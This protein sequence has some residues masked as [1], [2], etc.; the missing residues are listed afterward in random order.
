MIIVN[1][2]IDFFPL[3]QMAR[4]FTESVQ[5]KQHQDQIMN[6]KTVCNNIKIP[7]LNI[8]ND[9]LL[10][11]LINSIVHF[12]GF[13]VRSCRMRTLNFWN[14]CCNTCKIMKL[15]KSV[16]VRL[17]NLLTTKLMII[18]NLAQILRRCWSHFFSCWRHCL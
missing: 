10:I 3:D 13:T 4:Q 1:L 17:I 2:A 18:V 11:Y 6:N 12:C 15:R 7:R 9:W 16:E 14:I 5:L 8:E